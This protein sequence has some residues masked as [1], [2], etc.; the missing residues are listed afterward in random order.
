MKNVSIFVRI[1]TMVILI[2]LLFL[3]FVFVW[4]LPAT[5]DGLYQERMMALRAPV[6]MVYTYLD[7]M[8]VKVENKQLTREEAKS[9]ICEIVS[10]LKYEKGKNYVW[11]NDNKNVFV[12]HPNP[13][14]IGADFTDKADINGV[15]FI[16]E[17]TQ[18]T[19]KNGEG[20]IEYSFPKPDNPDLPLPK[21]SF[22]KYHKY[23]GYVVA[24]GVWID[25]IDKEVGD[26]RNKIIIGMV[27]GIII[28]VLIAYFLSK[29]IVNPIKQAR[30]R[31]LKMSEGE[32]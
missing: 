29:N 32:F 16:Y 14:N 22:G 6:E 4:V 30:D 28:S 11:L 9:K 3:I 1:M 13:K 8:M 7:S 12:Y 24:T 31:I 5:K 19:T 27:I 10:S 23:W 20:Y 21:K 26:I 15:R 18:I 25:D 17:I 2:V